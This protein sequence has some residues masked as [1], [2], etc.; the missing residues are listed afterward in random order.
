[1]YE[2]VFNVGTN[3]KRDMKIVL[4]FALKQVRFLVLGLLK[5]IRIITELNLS[6]TYLK[7]NVFNLCK[8]V[9]INS[10]FLSLFNRKLGSIT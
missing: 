4:W 8:L 6:F 10:L 9:F 2:L 1:M 7:V 5:R 3:F